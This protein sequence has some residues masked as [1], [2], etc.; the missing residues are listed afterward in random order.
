MIMEHSESK[1]QMYF[2][3]RNMHVLDGKKITYA[4]AI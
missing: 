2:T 3:S 4:V 1:D